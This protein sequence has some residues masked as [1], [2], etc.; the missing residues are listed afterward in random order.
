[1]SI[2]DEDKIDKSKVIN[3][4]LDNV[5]DDQ[6]LVAKIEYPEKSGVMYHFF[7]NKTHLTVFKYSSRRKIHDIHLNVPLEACSWV[8]YIITLIKTPPSKGGLPKGEHGKNNWVCNEHLRF[9][10]TG[11]M[12]S[13]INFSR[14][15]A[16]DFDDRWQQDLSMEYPLF[17]STEFQE[18]WQGIARDYPITADKVREV[19][20]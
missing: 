14:P 8:N 5:P 11:L 9:S 19:L 20:T 3:F 13:L 18:M 15:D 6:K 17:D 2:K 10:S 12:Y 4:T 7:K 1:M 16:D